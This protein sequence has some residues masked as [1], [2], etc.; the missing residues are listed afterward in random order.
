M[1]NIR[2]NGEP[3]MELWLIRL[4]SAIDRH[5]PYARLIFGGEVTA[6]VDKF[7]T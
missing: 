5:F 4:A 7:D 6:R 2:L 1:E 3:L